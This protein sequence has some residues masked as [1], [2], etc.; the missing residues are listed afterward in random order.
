[1]I[2]FKIKDSNQRPRSRAIYLTPVAPSKQ[3]VTRVAVSLFFAGAA[4]RGLI[5]EAWRMMRFLD[6]SPV[7]EEN[8]GFARLS[9]VVE[10]KFTDMWSH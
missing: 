2:N 8:K 4:I 5:L 1:M 6:I 10:A 3:N 9:K 7:E